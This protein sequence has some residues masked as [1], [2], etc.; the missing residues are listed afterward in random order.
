MNAELQQQLFGGEI[1]DYLINKLKADSLKENT[2]NNFNIGDLASIYNNQVSSKGSINNNNAGAVHINIASLIEQQ[3][4]DPLQAIL[5]NSLSRIASEVGL[6]SDNVPMA[7]ATT[8]L[9]PKDQ[10]T[11]DIDAARNNIA[12]AIAELQK[13]NAI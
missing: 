7:D 1:S 9:Q 3:P 10:T 6:E 5:N 2:N 13:L 8:L 11:A 4:P 12:N